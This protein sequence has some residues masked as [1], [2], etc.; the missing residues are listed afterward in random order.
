[1]NPS[2]MDM[3]TP[4]R[5]IF[6]RMSPQGFRSARVSGIPRSYFRTIHTEMPTLMAWLRTVPRAAPGWPHMERSHEQVVQ[7][8]VGHTGD[9]HGNT[10]EYGN[11]PCPGRWS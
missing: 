6:R 7:D 3:G 9:G 5:R 2:C 1:M 11:S 10:W 4:T 8:D